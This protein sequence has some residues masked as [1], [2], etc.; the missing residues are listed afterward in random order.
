MIRSLYLRNFQSHKE[1]ELELHPGVNVI[2]GDTDAGKSAIVR[3]LYW[4][5]MGKPSGD[6]FLRHNT[7]KACVVEVALDN[8][9]IVQRYRGHD[10]NSY[11]IGNDEHTGFG[12]N[13]PEP[14]QKVLNMNAINFSRQLDPPF[15]FSKSPGETAQYLNTLIN[16]DVIG[17]S[18]TNIGKEVKFA[19]HEMKKH[20]AMKDDLV[21]QYDS[22]AW[23][24]QAEKDVCALEQQEKELAKLQSKRNTLRKALQ[25]Y[26]AAKQTLDS[27]PNYKGLNEALSGLE[28]TALEV[29]KLRKSKLALKRALKQ[30]YEAVESEKAAIMQE[31]EI[32]LQYQ[33]EFPDICP[34]CDQ[35]IPAKRLA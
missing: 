25:D 7:K 26:Y 27:L 19:E 1:T 16:L 4:I 34:L 8:N 21:Q 18:L 30:Y 22:L 2:I 28:N 14:V 17:Q 35:P 5:A 13:V 23:V 32:V 6:S 24:E 15:L 12:Q 11:F 10:I 20:R 3:A 9:T 33:H 29:D 31:Q